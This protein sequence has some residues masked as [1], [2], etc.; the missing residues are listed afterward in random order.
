MAFINLSEYVAGMQ[1]G[2]AMYCEVLISE[3][4]R[5]TEEAIDEKH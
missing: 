2:W 5:R 3:E 4:A 1:R